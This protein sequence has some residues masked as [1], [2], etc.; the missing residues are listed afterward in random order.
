MD[1]DLSQSRKESIKVPEERKDTAVPDR[2]KSEDSAVEKCTGYRH[3][4]P[5]KTF[6]CQGSNCNMRPI[7]CKRCAF[8]SLDKSSN[9]ICKM[10][11]VTEKMRDFSVE[12]AGI[13]I[14]EKN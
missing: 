12:A 11:R 7:I 10:C 5:K 3:L 8:E 14:D 9:L 1:P 2:Y 13:E 6:E 4:D